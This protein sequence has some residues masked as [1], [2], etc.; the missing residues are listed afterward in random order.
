MPKFRPDWHRCVQLAQP[1]RRS[2]AA[3]CRRHTPASEPGRGPGGSGGRSRSL[4]RRVRVEL[5]GG[6]G[7]RGCAATHRQHDRSRRCRH[8]RT[9]LRPCARDR[10]SARNSPRCQVRRGHHRGEATLGGGGWPLGCR[11]GRSRLGLIGPM[12]LPACRRR[13]WWHILAC[14]HRQGSRS[15]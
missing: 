11:A 14:L 5:G 3:Q 13:R 10:R 1:V 4:L 9:A 12:S 2:L 7:T 15:R 6:V 8:R